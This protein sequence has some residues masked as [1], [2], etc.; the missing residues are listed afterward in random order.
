MKL[1]GSFSYTGSSVYNLKGIEESPNGLALFDT[2]TGVGGIDYMPYHGSTVKV[3][4]GLIGDDPNAIDFTPTLNNKLYYLVSDRAYN[5]TQRDLIIQDATEITMT[6]VG[7]RYE[8]SFVFSNPSDYE[9]L[10]LIWDNVNKIEG[11]ASYSGGESTKYINVDFGSTI[12]NAGIDHVLTGTPARFVLKYNNVVVGDTGYIGLNSPDNYNELISAGVDPSDIKLSTPLNGLVD[13]GTGSITF[14]KNTASGEAVLIVYSPLESTSWSLTQSDPSLTSFYIDTT[15]GTIS[16]VCSQAA[17]DQKWHD[18]VDSLPTVGC[19]VYDDADGIIGYDGANSYHLMSATSMGAPP[20]SGGVFMAI[21]ADG[22]CYSY[23]ECDCS[24]VAVPVINQGDIPLVMN[25]NV[26]IVISAT[27]NPTSWEI[28]TDCNQY[29]LT[30][31]DKGSIFSVENCKGITKNVSVNANGSIVKCAAST[32]VLTFGS[33]SVTLIGVCQNEILPE[34]LTFNTSTGILSGT[35]TTTCNYELELIATNCFGD[36]AS[37][38]INISIASGMN[39]TPFAMDIENFSDNGADTCLINAV[40]TLMYHNGTGNV[41]V[42]GDTIFID[43]K[44]IDKFMGGER[45]YKVQDSLSSLKVCHNGKVCD[46]H[47]C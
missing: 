38:T 42:V 4:S 2:L 44:G 34:G 20:V 9:Y 6:L 10:Y 19:R 7:G 27:N 30:G 12:G 11:T 41:P 35:P 25:E 15:N 46:S 43:H 23:G 13:N 31:G 26:N 32:P 29:T 33:G 5:E 18:G 45:F 21:D 8:G 24:E 17:N 1:N 36:S 37:E 14:S 39:L 47:V 3:F 40:Y 22:I 16:N 28:V